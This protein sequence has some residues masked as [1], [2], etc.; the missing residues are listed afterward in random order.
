MDHILGSSVPELGRPQLVLLATHISRTKH[1]SAGA[2]LRLIE[3]GGIEPEILA[4][5]V[6]IL[7]E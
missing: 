4:A 2:A 3:S 6:K 5:L 7:K 1:I